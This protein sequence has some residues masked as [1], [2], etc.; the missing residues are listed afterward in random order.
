MQGAMEGQCPGRPGTSQGGSSGQGASSEAGASEAMG[1]ALAA[2]AGAVCGIP[3][4]DIVPA[5]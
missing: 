2:V 4:P 1:I 3:I 5:G